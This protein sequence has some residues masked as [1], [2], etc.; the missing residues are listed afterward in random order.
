MADKTLQ[1]RERGPDPAAS[2]RSA[3]QTTVRAVLQALWPGRHW[4]LTLQLATRELAARFRGQGLGWAWLVLAPLL[5][6]A[7]YTVVLT[8]V[9]GVRWGTAAAHS[10]GTDL[11]F[12]LQLY[13][14]LAVFAFFSEVVLRAPRLITNVPHLVKR[15]VFPLEILP[16]VSALAAMVTLVLAAALLLAGT[17]ATRGQLPVSAL[18]LPLVWLPLLPLTLGLGWLLAAV[19]TYIRDVGEVLGLALGALLF[20]S[21]VFYDAASLPP[22]LQLPLGLNPLAVVMTQTRQVVLVGQWPAWDVWAAVMLAGVMAAL[23]GAA[24][25]TRVRSGFADVV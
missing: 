22:A 13:A 17:A 20:L 24:V 10:S 4:G 14:G 16:W 6:L 25:F 21:P 2:P 5:M 18:A 9:L 8:Q 19:G 11:E 15:V 12:A 23:L 1:K 3:G 7:V